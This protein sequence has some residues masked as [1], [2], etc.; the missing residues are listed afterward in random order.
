[1]LIYAFRKLM[2][3]DE[4]AKVDFRFICQEEQHSCDEE[5]VVSVVDFEPF[6]SF[7]CISKIDERLT[8]R[9]VE[10]KGVC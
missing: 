9:L 4:G 1:M 8:A 2:L 6:R 10:V 5:F 3:I 7:W